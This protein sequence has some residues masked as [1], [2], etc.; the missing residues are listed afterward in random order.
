MR[1]NRQRMIGIV[2]SL[3][4]VVVSILNLL[5][6]P[7]QIDISP[8]NPKFR[9]ALISLLQSESLPTEDLPMDLSNFFMATDNGF[10]VGAVGLEIYGR[11]GLLRSLIVKPEYRKSKI[12]RSLISE[13]ERRAKNLG[14]N[15]VYLLTE[16]AQGY[17]PKIGYE[18][19]SREDA[20]DSLKQSTE[21]S[22]VCPTSAIFMKNKI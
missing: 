15:T 11:T 6:M 3:E 19:V 17:F 10:I 2:V 7:N 14:L 13:L 18:A 5:N 8:I 4:A 1:I 12:A 16:T 20:P 21:F 22:H 9:P